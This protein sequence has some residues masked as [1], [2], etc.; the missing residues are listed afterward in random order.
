MNECRNCQWYRRGVSEGLCY[1]APPVPLIHP[2]YGVVGLRPTTASDD[3]C[4]EFVSR[5]E[6]S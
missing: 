5:E 2:V 4:S 1:F 6:G 3:F